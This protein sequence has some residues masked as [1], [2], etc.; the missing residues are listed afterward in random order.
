MTIETSKG[1]VLRTRPLT[2][3][4]LIVHWLTPDLGRLAMVAKGARGSKSAFRGKMDL[5]YE[6]EFSFVRSRV[7]ELHNL[8]EVNLIET[9]GFLRREFAALQHVC[10]AAALLEQTTETE[11]PL[12]ELY[13]LMINLLRFLAGR[14]DAP[15]AVTTFEL[16]LLDEL[17][18]MPDLESTRLQPGTKILMRKMAESSWDDIGRLK[19]APAQAEEIRRFLNGFLIYQFG[20]LPKGRG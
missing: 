14:P 7:S 11:T 19:P 18:L 4:S 13:E 3:T 9:N 15:Q 17:G 10:Y 8:R 2:E 1:L 6:A 5:F 16:K 12:P 20:R